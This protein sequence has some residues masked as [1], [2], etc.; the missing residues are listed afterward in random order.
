MTAAPLFSSNVEGASQREVHYGS[1]RAVGT[2][3]FT[4][5][6]LSTSVRELWLDEAIL[7]QVTKYTPNELQALLTSPSF[8]KLH[9]LGRPAVAREE[10]PQG[11]ADADF[12]KAARDKV[13]YEEYPDG[14]AP[15]SRRTRR[16][17]SDLKLQRRPNYPQT[18][19]PAAST[20]GGRQQQQPTRR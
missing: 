2:E 18:T 20:N 7:S 11:M 4:A 15:P 9:C 5:L 8:K 10:I 6:R 16:C 1:C 17:T 14:Y 3:I 12:P 19:I 13:A